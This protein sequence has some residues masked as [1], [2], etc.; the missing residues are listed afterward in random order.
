MPDYGIESSYT[1][2]DSELFTEIEDQL[3]TAQQGTDENAINLA[4][5]R[6]KKTQELL[7]GQLNYQIDELPYKTNYINALKE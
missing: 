7:T 2:T 4:K 1:S 6:V 3:K 5:E